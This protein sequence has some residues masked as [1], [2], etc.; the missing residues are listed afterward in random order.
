MASFRER[1]RSGKGKRRG[2]YCGFKC[3][4]VGERKAP[5]GRE[6]TG[7]KNMYFHI[8]QR[9]LVQGEE[10]FFNFQGRKHVSG[11]GSLNCP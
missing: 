6:L 4:K 7:C 11:G 5:Q 9:N 8:F 3:A 2:R 10:V 1:N